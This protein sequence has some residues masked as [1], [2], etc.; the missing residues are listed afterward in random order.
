MLRLADREI[1]FQ[2]LQCKKFTMIIDR[3][4]DLIMALQMGFDASG[5][6]LALPRN[7]EGKILFNGFAVN[8]TKPTAVK[9]NELTFTTVDSATI[10]WKGNNFE[11]EEGKVVGGEVTEIIVKFGD[12]TFYEVSELEDIDAAELFSLAVGGQKASADPFFDYLLQGDDI[13]IGTNLNDDIG[14]RGGNDTMYGRKGNDTIT[15]GIGQD[16]LFGGGGNDTLIGVDPFA[17]EKDDLDDADILNET[18]LGANFTGEIDVLSG[19]NGNDVFVLGED[20][21]TYYVG[22]KYQ[23]YAIIEDFQ[24]T[25]DL[26]QL[27]SAP[28]N[29]EVSA[30]YIIDGQSGAGILFNDDLVAIVMGV[31]A[32]DLLLPEVSLL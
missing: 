1:D 9:S 11:V 19:G 24:R 6:P 5:L 13:S 8:P 30:N 4:E 18:G 7:A 21:K 20:S 10:T 3:E 14:G 27:G 15:G 26:F 23:D 31:S 29:Y 2:G 28:K 17:S 25:Q 16:Q 32:S 12:Q 22:G